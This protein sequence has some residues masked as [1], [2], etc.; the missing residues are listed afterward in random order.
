MKIWRSSTS[1]AEGNGQPGW[2]SPAPLWTCCIWS[3][4]PSAGAV[5][6][7]E[8]H[9]YP[10]PW[11]LLHRKLG[12]PL[13]CQGLPHAL[14]RVSAPPEL[15]QHLLVLSWAPCAMEHFFF[16]QKHFLL[17][18]T[19]PADK[20]LLLLRKEI[21]RAHPSATCR[22]TGHVARHRKPLMEV[23]LPQLGSPC[24]G[25]GAWILT[26]TPGL[27]GCLALC[28]KQPLGT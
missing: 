1:G 7:C 21:E 28:W 26:Q 18:A 14:W 12:Q 15:P 8:G 11:Q 20:V 25:P 5:C 19:S 23:K 4:E 16:S 2:L 13:P 17:L 27:V 24:W 9:G 6:T 22:T 3:A 10:G